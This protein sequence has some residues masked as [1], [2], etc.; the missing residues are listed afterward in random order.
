MR[1]EEERRGLMSWRSLAASGV[2]WSEGNDGEGWRLGVV[3]GSSRHGVVVLSGAVLGVS[4][5]QSERGWSGGLRQLSSGGYGGGQS[6]EMAKE[7]EK[8]AA[9]WGGG[10]APFIAA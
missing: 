5:S 6:G 4:S 2:A 9:R 7:E 1:P 10:V 8:G 3:V